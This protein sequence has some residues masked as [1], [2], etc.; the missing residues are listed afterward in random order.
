MTKLKFKFNFGVSHFQFRNPIRIGL[1]Q[2]RDKLK[3][4]LPSVLYGM[5]L[6][7]KNLHKKAEKRLQLHG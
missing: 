7:K 1:I 6:L 5:L 2:E 3:S 4:R